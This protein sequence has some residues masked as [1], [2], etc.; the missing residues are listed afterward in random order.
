MGD[1]NVA[2][3]AFIDQVDHN[4]QTTDSAVLLDAVITGDTD[5]VMAAVRIVVKDACGK[6]KLLWLGSPVGTI[7]RNIKTGESATRAI[8]PAGIPLWTISKPDGGREDNHEPVL[9][10]EADWKCIYN[11]E[12][13]I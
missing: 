1:T 9:Q 10:P 2:Y 7:L 4:L 13:E 6:A 11:P 3:D 12:A 8:S 5:Q